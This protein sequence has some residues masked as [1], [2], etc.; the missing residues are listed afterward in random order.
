MAEGQPGQQL[1]GSLPHVACL[2]ATWYN[3][4]SG[5]I[6]S[7]LVS[8]SFILLQR[9]QLCDNLQWFHFTSRPELKPFDNI[10]Q[11]SELDFIEAPSTTAL[12]DRK[13]PR[14]PAST[15]TWARFHC[16]PCS[17]MLHA[18][19]TET[20]TSAQSCHVC[21]C[22]CAWSISCSYLQLVSH[23][24]VPCCPLPLPSNTTDSLCARR[25]A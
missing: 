8:D 25:M 20:A 6:C 14:M 17:K 11:V 12:G 22:V 18:D 5:A 9:P 21:V 23:H 2:G 3:R 24:S 10:R 1:K 16:T 19:A 7:R 15:A 13:R 4:N